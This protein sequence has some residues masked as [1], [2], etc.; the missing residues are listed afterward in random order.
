MRIS[1]S[2]P[3][4]RIIPKTASIFAAKVLFK[5]L[6]PAEASTD[7]NEWVSAAFVLSGGAL[8]TIFAFLHQYPGSVPWISSGRVS[9]LSDGRL[10]TSR[11]HVEGNKFGLSGLFTYYG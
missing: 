4:N 9:F 1:Y 3:S 6:G 5:L 8:L 11:Y 7:L 10:S 2:A